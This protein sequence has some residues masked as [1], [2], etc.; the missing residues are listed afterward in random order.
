MADYIDRQAAIEKLQNNIIYMQ[1]FGVD[2]AVTLIDEVPSA[3]VQPVRHGWW[4]EDKEVEFVCSEC[5]EQCANTVM[6]MPRDRYCKWC[7]ARMDFEKG[8]KEK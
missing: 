3:D 6:G 7:G 8:D 4:I 2:R 5:G 1:T